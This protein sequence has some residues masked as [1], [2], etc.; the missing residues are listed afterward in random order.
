MNEYSAG[1]AIYIATHADAGYIEEDSKLLRSLM[2]DVLAENDIKPYVEIDYTNRKVKEIDVHALEADECTLLFVTNYAT[3]DHSGFFS[4]EGKSLHIRLN[5]DVE[6]VNG[7]IST[8]EELLEIVRG[9]GHI[10]LEVSVKKNETMII[11]LNKK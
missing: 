9:L 6:Y 2:K 4:G 3:M 1:K 8:S 11:K 5:N 10:D 7:E